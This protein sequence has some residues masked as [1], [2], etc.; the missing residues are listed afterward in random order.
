MAFIQY[1]L[2]LFQHGLLTSSPDINLKRFGH[3]KVFVLNM[4]LKSSQDL[5]GWRAFS[6]ILPSQI[7]LLPVSACYCSIA[8]DDRVISS[9]INLVSMLSVYFVYFWFAAQICNLNL[10]N[11]LLCNSAEYNLRQVE[12]P[13][14]K[15]I[16]LLRIYHVL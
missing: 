7:A 12:V 9:E 1:L 11:V 10:W 4:N 16:N 8:R 2:Y 15:P 3:N 5:D 6:W 13:E 14:C